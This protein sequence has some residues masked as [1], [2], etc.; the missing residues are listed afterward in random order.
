MGYSIFFSIIN[1]F[2]FVWARASSR[3]VQAQPS[4]T[5]EAPANTQQG[6]MT[7]RDI[8]LLRQMIVVFCTF[9]IGWGPIYLLVF[10]SGY[11]YI[12][13]LV[14]P[15]IVIIAPMGLWSGLINLFVHHREVRE[16]LREKIGRVLRMRAQ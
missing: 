11:F 4:T 13:P 1:I 5:G 7:R 6:R 9:V 14:L 15:C 16:Y 12:N 10:L 3:R 2:V 8:H